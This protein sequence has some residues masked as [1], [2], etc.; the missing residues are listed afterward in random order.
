MVH[1]CERYSLCASYSYNELQDWCC[2]DIICQVNKFTVELLCFLCLFLWVQGPFLCAIAEQE[3]N[4][5]VMCHC[6]F[7]FLNINLRHRLL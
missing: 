1:Q 2:V 7:L 6:A 4:K 3:P 5:V